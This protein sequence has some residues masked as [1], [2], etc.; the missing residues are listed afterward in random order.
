MY[1]SFFLRASLFSFSERFYA[2]LVSWE[3]R[4]H[5]WAAELAAHAEGPARLPSASPREQPAAQRREI[6]STLEVSAVM[7]SSFAALP[8]VKVLRIVVLEALA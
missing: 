8:Y 7:T 2:V 6:S 1:S 5:R 3:R 4:S